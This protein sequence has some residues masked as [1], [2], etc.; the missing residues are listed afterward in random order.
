MGVEAA[1]AGTLRGRQRQPRARGGRG[2]ERFA[3]FTAPVVGP[4]HA[5]VEATL[6]RRFSAMVCQPRVCGGRGVARSAGGAASVLAPRARGS[7][8][9]PHPGRQPR[10]VSPAYAG[11]EGGSRTVWR[12]RQ[13]RPHVRGGRGYAS[14]LDFPVDMSAP[15]CGGSHGPAADVVLEWD[16]ARAPGPGWGARTPPSGLAYLVGVWPR[17]R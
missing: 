14:K 4:V 7:R 2:I 12:P 16:P 13:R 10:K 1:R 8:L 3:T 9:V 17:V 15:A 11:V 6:P 5:G